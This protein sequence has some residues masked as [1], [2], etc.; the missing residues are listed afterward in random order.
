MRLTGYAWPGNVRQL[1]NV[2]ENMVVMAIGDRDD[3]GGTVRVEVGH[4]PAEI[5]S[6]DADG[7]PDSGG[8]QTGSLAGTSLEQLE[9]QAIRETLKLTGGNREQTAKLLGIGE[10]TLYRKLKEYG[11]R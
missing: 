4:I 1:I 7:L 2:V 6:S 8:A 9:K 5:M 10:R 3:D 11:L